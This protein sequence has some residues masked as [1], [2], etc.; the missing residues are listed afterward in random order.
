LRIEALLVALVLLLAGMAVARSRSG[1]GP[2]TACQILGLDGFTQVLG[3][4]AGAPRAF[5]PPGKVGDSTGCRLGG[6]PGPS[7]MAFVVA[8]EPLANFESIRAVSP[9][10]GAS[11]DADGSGYRAFVLAAPSS[12]DR[13]TG[14]SPS[15]SETLLVFRNDTFVKVELGSVPTGS[16]ARLAPSIASRLG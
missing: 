1:G 9:Q 5:V 3:S 10:L 4:D 6:L 12:D 2:P 11:T 13:R 7:A 15:T 16:A 8:H 14:S